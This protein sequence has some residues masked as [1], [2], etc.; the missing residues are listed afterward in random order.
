MLTCFL[1]YFFHWGFFLFICN[2]TLY[3][4]GRQGEWELPV[5]WNPTVEGRGGLTNLT[6][7][8]ILEMNGRNHLLD[9]LM[10]RELS[11]RK[12]RIMLI[13]FTY[14][15][16]V[17]CFVRELKL[18]IFNVVVLKLSS[19]T[20]LLESVLVCSSLRMEKRSPLLCLMMVAWISSKKM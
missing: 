15:E 5:S 18:E 19:Q 4:V 17:L 6:R 2:W 1:F 11:W 12:C 3:N 7:S 20:L 8:R 14:Y 9:L 16:Y 13:L 10:L